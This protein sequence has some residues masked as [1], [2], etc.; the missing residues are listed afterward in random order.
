MYSASRL[1]NMV[2]IRKRNAYFGTNC[3]FTLVCYFYFRA[4]GVES[5]PPRR[6]HNVLTSRCSLI[7]LFFWPCSHNINVEGLLSSA[8]ECVDADC[9]NRFFSTPLRDQ[10]HG[11]SCK[12]VCFRFLTIILYIYIYY[13]YIMYIIYD[14]I[15]SNRTWGPHFLVPTFL[16]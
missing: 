4:L 6:G 8:P 9:W 5:P 15:A 14:Y 13:I 2:R 1:Q 7:R 3:L 10:E 12:Y 11:C 16:P